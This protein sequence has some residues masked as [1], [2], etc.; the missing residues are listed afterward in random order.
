MT[1]PRTRAAAPLALLL[2]LAA[3]GGPPAASVSSAQPSSPSSPSASSKAS[4]SP[5]APPKPT[6][7]RATTQTWRLPFPVARQVVLPD[8]R[9]PG[10]VVVAGGLLPGDQTTGRSF[11]LDLSTGHVM[12][13]PPLGVPVHDAAGG[14]YAGN[15]A[16]FGGGNATEQS[17][18]QALVGNRWRSVDRM[19]TTRS[20]LVVADTT[21]GTLVIG[22]YD[23]VNVPRKILRQRGSGSLQSWGTLSAGVRYAAAVPL[24]GAVYVFGGEVNQRE[25]DAVQRID[26][27]TGR[28]RVVGHLPRPLGHAQAVAVGGRILLMGG[29]TDASTQTAQMWWFDAGTAHVTRAGRLPVPISDAAAVAQGGSVWLLGGESPLMRD[30]VVRIRV[31]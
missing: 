9:R 8:Q 17:V 12:D 24:G 19:P 14:T 11:R 21:A 6:R 13:L 27:R 16:V 7:A 22:G 28:T 15:P 3:C 2:L 5:S 1:G 30:R 18:V 10:Q 23:G 26:L 4:A 25:L 20:D 31:S 29:R